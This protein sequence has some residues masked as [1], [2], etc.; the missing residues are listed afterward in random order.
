MDNNQT[1]VGSHKISLGNRKSALITGVKDVVSFD[2]GEVLLETTQGMLLI[3][4]A[5]LHVSRLSL[6]RGE[7]DVDGTVNS[8]TYSDVHSASKAA[9][10]LLRRLFK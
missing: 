8:M 1:M 10:S 2:A 4:G 7:V 3:K 9:G 5:E 6:E